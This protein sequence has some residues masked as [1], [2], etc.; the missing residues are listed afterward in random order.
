MRSRAT[1]NHAGARVCSDTNSDT[2]SVIARVKSSKQIASTASDDESPKPR[3]S[4]AN[5]IPDRTTLRSSVY[6]AS[7]NVTKSVAM[8]GAGWVVDQRRSDAHRV[9]TVCTGYV[10]TTEQ[11]DEVRCLMGV[12]LY[13]SCRVR[14][15]AGNCESSGRLPATQVAKELGVGKDPPDAVVGFIHDMSP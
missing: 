3:S 11:Y 9:G 13:L 12:T 5:R 10:L 2:R 14:T 7:S 4:L 6:I 15:H 1:R 8:S